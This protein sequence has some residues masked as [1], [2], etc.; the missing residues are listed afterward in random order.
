MAAGESI[1]IPFSNK[2]LIKLLAVSVVFVLAGCWLLIAQ[3]EMSNSVFNDPFTRNTTAVCCVLFF[4]FAAI[5]FALKIRA[6]KPALIIDETGITNNTGTVTG[7]H[8]PWSD[9]RAIV[10]NTVFNQ[11]FLMV[12]LLLTPIT[13]NRFFTDS[14]AASRW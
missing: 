6:K 13:P 5:V 3:P 14:L 2:K 8:I 1:I 10:T 11:V 12:I 4:G 9:I 7:D